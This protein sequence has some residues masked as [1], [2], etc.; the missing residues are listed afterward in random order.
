[1][2]P[3][4]DNTPLSQIKNLN[5]ERQKLLSSTN[6]YKEALAHQVTDLKQNTIKLA[7]QGLVFAGIALG[8]YLLV[9]AFKKKDKFDRQDMKPSIIGGITSGLF[10]SIQS[11]IASFL[12]AIARE[13]ITAFL[14]T[15]FLK[16]DE[17]IRKNHSESGL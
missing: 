9:R 10:A 12:L 8:S 7:I 13:K 14:E 2:N 15:Q 5:M 11:Y 6:K 1:M 4:I 17:T 16:Q 3:L